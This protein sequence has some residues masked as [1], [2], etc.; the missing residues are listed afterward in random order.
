MFS[1]MHVPFFRR[2]L[3]HGIQCSAFSTFDLYSIEHG[4]KSIT[5]MNNHKHDNEKSY[6]LQKKSL[7]KIKKKIN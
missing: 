2:L 3:S 1:N 4:L 5:V 6:F 7:G